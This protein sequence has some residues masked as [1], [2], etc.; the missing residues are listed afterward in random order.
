MSQ[1]RAKK[2]DIGCFTKIR[3]IRDHTKRKVYAE[4][5]PERQALRYIIR[6]TTFPQRVRA[7]AQLQLAQ[8]HCYTR[9]TQVKN[10]CI[11]GGRGRGVFSDFRLGRYQ[12]RMNALAGN[13]PGVKKASW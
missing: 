4:H 13:L 11:M 1:F 10:R 12:F 9:F 5:E 3:N 8:M 2:L 6:N 7:Q